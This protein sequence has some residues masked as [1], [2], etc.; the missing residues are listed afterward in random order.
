MMSKFIDEGFNRLIEW[1]KEFETHNEAIL[2]S[3]E[4]KPEDFEELL[5]GARITDK[6]EWAKSPSF[7]PQYNPDKYGIFTLKYVDQWSVGMEGDS[8]EGY[9]Y[10]EVEGYEKLLKIPY[11]C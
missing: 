6:I 2:N 10:V 9:M 4:H 8:F 5:E 1:E 3:I 11:S 7:K